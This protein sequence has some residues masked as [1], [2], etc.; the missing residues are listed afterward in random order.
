MFV[1][2]S[3]LEV[4]VGNDDHVWIL[5]LVALGGKVCLSKWRSYI[6]GFLLVAFHSL[7]L[8]RLVE[9]HLVPSKSSIVVLPF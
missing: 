1:N 3:V 4:E 8:P 6:L 7:N 5:R 2:V 9:T